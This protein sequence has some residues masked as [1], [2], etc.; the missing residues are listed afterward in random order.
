[1][2]TEEAIQKLGRRVLCLHCNE[3]IEPD[4]L[5]VPGVSVLL[6]PSGVPVLERCAMHPN[7]AMRAVVGSRGHVEHE[8]CS[9]EWCPDEPGL[10]KRQAADAAVAAFNRLRAN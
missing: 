4:E 10:T 3:S 8:R 9:V 6:G 1:M 5:A 7:C 2:R